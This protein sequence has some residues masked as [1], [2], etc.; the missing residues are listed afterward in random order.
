MGIPNRFNQL[1]SRSSARFLE[2]LAPDAATLLWARVQV[3][4]QCVMALPHDLQT[5]PAMVQ[6][7]RGGIARLSDDGPEPSAR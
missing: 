4:W 3:A 6:L 1:G 5:I 2:A 7:A